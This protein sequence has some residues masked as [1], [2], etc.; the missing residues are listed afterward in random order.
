MKQSK[1]LIPTRQVADEEIDTVS[2]RLLSQAGYVTKL[3]RGIYAYLPLA[4]RVIQK[5]SRVIQSELSTQNSIKMRMP[6]LLPH[7]YSLEECETQVAEKLFSVND[8]AGETYML[9]PAHERSFMDLIMKEVRSYKELPL[10]LFQTQM[11]YRDETHKQRGLIDSREFL[12]T[13]VYSF[14]ADQESLDQFYR[15]MEESIERILTTCG[16]TFKVVNG[17]SKRV[18][19]KAM[20]EFIVPTAIGQK[21]FCYASEGE[22]AATLAVA[23]SE[24]DTKKSHATYQ[25]LEEI[26]EFDIH[27]TPLNQTIKPL[28]YRVK[29]E[30]IV[31]L[32]RADHQV[33]EEKIKR[34][35]QVPSI[36]LADQETIVSFFGDIQTDDFFAR[37]NQLPIYADQ[38]LS[39]LVNAQ[40]NSHTLARAY[41]NVNFNRDIQITQFL[42]IQLVKEGDL[43]LNG[44]GTLLFDRGISVAQMTKLAPDYARQVGA[45][46]LDDQAQLQTLNM[47]YYGIG[48]TRIFALIVEMYAME[49]KMCWPQ[50]IAPFD[51]HILPLD[52]TDPF[53]VELA[54][55]VALELDQAGY[56]L[57]IDDRETSAANK[58]QDAALIG[59]PIQCTIGKKAVEGIV[60]LEIKAKQAVLEVRKEELLTTLSILLQ[61]E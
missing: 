2:E 28:F 44:Q 36:T 60:E 56:D 39:E 41:R 50:A 48:V 46:F 17:A 45:I 7:E 20:R 4:E 49:D 42:D 31:L 25:P 9:A 6:N 27:T 29:E 57:L 59:C 43:A 55:Q 54:T 22:Y 15:Q 35:F 37:L 33:N 58:E 13:D 34:F 14:H 51:V 40:F 8:A 18:G 12:M 24:S 61:S 47:G 5:I 23:V 21:E 19:A 52:T 38:G 3:A 1:L 11:K 16:L 32:L 53:Q 30:L 26:A 10:S